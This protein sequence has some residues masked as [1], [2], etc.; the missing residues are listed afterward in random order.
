MVAGYSERQLICL[1]KKLGKF[2][3][4]RWLACRSGRFGAKPPVFSAQIRALD[5]GVGPKSPSPN[6]RAN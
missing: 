1:I 5:S 6:R 3:A 2:E 4:L